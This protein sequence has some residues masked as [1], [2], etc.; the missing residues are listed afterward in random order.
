MKRMALILA[1]TLTVAAPLLSLAAHDHGAMGHGDMMAGG[2]AAHEEVVNG[3]RAT[4]EVLDMRD[5]MHGEM[6]KGMK[7]THHVMVTFTDAKSGKK[8]TEGEV[9]VKIQGPEKT[10]QTRDLR[11]MQGHF[12]ADFNLSKKGSYGV[13]CKF[14]LKDGTVRQARFWY[15]VK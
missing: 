12:G 9:K 10:E 7:E 5:Q 14:R 1:A 11:G 6:P 2:Q 15:T 13:M 3:V 8:I 4:F